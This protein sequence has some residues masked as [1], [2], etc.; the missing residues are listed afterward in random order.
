[1]GYAAEVRVPAAISCYLSLQLVLRVIFCVADMSL[2]ADLDNLSQGQFS[3]GPARSMSCS[4]TQDPL[5]LDAVARV[6]KSGRAQVTQFQCRVMW[7][8]MRFNKRGIIYFTSSKMVTHEANDR[9]ADLVL[10][11]AS[12]LTN[13]IDLFIYLVGQYG[14]SR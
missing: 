8:T 2:P 12:Y 3:Q 5:E 11:D 1:M 9:I 4:G 10:L 7:T 13:R 6:S 14:S